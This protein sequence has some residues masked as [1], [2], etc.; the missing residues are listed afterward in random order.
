[1]LRSTERGIATAKSSLCPW[2]SGIVI[3]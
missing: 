3:T 1:M 2:R